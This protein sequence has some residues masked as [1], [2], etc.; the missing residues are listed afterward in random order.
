MPVLYCIVLK[1]DCIFWRIN[2][3]LGTGNRIGAMAHHP[4]A[5][6]NCLTHRGHHPSPGVSSPWRDS[7]W[8]YC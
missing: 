8:F 7:F 2:A 5:V 3:A 6:G 1:Q 4:P